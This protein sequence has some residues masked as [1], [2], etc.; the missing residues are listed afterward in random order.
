MSFGV[1]LIVNV[2]TGRVAHEYINFVDV[3]A[4]GPVAALV[5]LTDE[6]IPDLGRDVLKI[7]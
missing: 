5:D 2:L 1:E 3:L 4:R 6:I 7:S